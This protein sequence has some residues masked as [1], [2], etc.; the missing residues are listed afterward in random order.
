MQLLLKMLNED[1]ADLRL[2]QQVYEHW[3][4]TANTDF[5]EFA[6]KLCRMLLCDIFRPSPFSTLGDKPRHSN[7][8]GLLQSDP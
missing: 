5:A 7:C 4:Q 8:L 6:Q 3:P 1:S 2:T